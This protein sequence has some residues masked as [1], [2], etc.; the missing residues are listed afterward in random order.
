MHSFVDIKLVPHSEFW[1][2]LTVW[3][4]LILRV[5]LSLRHGACNFLMIIITEYFM[6]NFLIDVYLFRAFESKT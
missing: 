4:F 5:V 2:G 6:L 3:N 1:N